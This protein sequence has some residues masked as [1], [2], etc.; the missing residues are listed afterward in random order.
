MLGVFAIA[1]VTAVGCAGGTA[2][3]PGAGSAADNQA[4][5]VDVLRRYLNAYN[6]GDVRRMND[7]ACAAA[8]R[9]AAAPPLLPTVVHKIG[10]ADIAGD[11]A[12]VPVSLSIETR[13]LPSL[14]ASVNIGVVKED[15][16][17]RFCMMERPTAA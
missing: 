7:T 14:P 5:I 13:G 2:R 6:A 10:V 15:G 9:G 16:M 11:S 3:A 1:S 12:T 17:W 8:Q 4:E